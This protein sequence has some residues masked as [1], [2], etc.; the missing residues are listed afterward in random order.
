[1]APR[2]MNSDALSA[3]MMSPCVSRLGKESNQFLRH[4]TSMNNDPPTLVSHG[5]LLP[6]AVMRTEDYSTQQPTGRYSDFKSPDM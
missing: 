2:C 4:T 6:I 1:M 3:Y 5:S